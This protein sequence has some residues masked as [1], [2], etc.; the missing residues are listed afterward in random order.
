MRDEN[1]AERVG[2]Q[3]DALHALADVL[4]RERAALL[5]RD[6]DALEAATRDKETLL[7]RLRTFSPDRDASTRLAGS[8]APHDELARLA[9]RCHREN[10][11]NGALLEAQRQQTEQL[12]AIVT[13]RAP[14]GRAAYGPRGAPS[15]PT[16]GRIRTTA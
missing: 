6:P 14:E 8:S 3:I 5:A 9:H 10:R 16:G 11:L 12:L 4:A 7:E 13:G 1:G 15:S 2:Q